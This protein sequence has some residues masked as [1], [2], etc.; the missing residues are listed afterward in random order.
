MWISHKVLW[1][2]KVRDGDCSLDENGDGVIAVAVV[3]S[4]VDLDFTTDLAADFDPGEELVE[5]DKNTVF[6]CWIAWVV[7]EAT[8]SSTPVDLKDSSSGVLKSFA[9]LIFSKQYKT[10]G[11]MVGF[12]RQSS[13]MLEKDSR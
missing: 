1:D 4:D 10:S 7:R 13:E 5:W 8:F 12:F 9:V 11:R 6:S 2:T 3:G